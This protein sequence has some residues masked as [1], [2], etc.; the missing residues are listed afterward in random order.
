ML[1]Q[2]KKCCGC[3]SEDRKIYHYD[4]SPETGEIASEGAGQESKPPANLAAAEE[5]LK[6]KKAKNEDD[7]YVYLPPGCS[8]AD[9]TYNSVTD[10][11][12]SR[13]VYR[14]DPNPSP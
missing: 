11:Q 10:P 3:S 4:K 9:P 7:I 8:V 2:L 1:I 5:R 6:G 12:E 14:R 13:R